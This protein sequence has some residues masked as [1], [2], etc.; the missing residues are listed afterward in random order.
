MTC[1]LNRFCLN[2]QMQDFL[3]EKK[4]FPCREANRACSVTEVRWI[5]ES[6]NICQ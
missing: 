2:V 3:K 4:E 5:V 6:G 1:I